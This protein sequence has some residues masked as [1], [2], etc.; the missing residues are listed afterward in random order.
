MFAVFVTSAIIRVK[1]VFHL[2][3]KLMRVS[4][5]KAAEHH[6]DILTAAARL[7]REQ[8]ISATGVDAIP[9]EARLTHG[10]VYSQFGSKEA[11]A[12]E[13]IRLAMQGSQRLWQRL[14]ERKGGE[15][16][17]PAIVAAYLSR[18]HCDAPGQGCVVAALGSEI[19]RQPPSV[20][21]VFTEEL[22]DALEFLAEL[23]PE[24]TPSRQYEDAIAVFAGMVGALI[25]ARAVSDETLSKRI[26]HVTAER[27]TR[28]PEVR[29]PAR[30]AKRTR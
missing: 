27:I 13:A 3:E 28:Q 26:L 23:M 15:K 19:A 10:A 20:R 18:E 29:P 2:K 17:F 1:W 21:K 25:L 22:K 8:G 9:K 5:E 6:H 7:F 24:D 30:R 4:K 14:V 12:T 16:V 11:I